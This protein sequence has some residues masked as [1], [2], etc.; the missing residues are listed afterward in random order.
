[1]VAEGQHRNNTRWRLPAEWERRAGSL[2]AWPYLPGPAQSAL[3]ALYVH[4]ISLLRTVEPVSLLVAPDDRRRVAG[5][6]GGED[7]SL[8]LE[9]LLSND[10][11]MRDAGPISVVNDAGQVLFL[12]GNFNGWGRRFAHELDTLLPLVLSR[13]WGYRRQRLGLCLEGGAIE[14]NGRGLGLTTTPVLTHPNRNNPGRQQI[15]SELERWLGVQDLVWLPHGLSMDHTDGHIDNLVRFVDPSHLVCCVADR[16][17]PD[18]AALS[19]NRAVVSAALGAAYT[20]I[21]LPTPQ[22]RSSSGQWL[23]ASHANFYLASGLALVPGF[24]DNSD[25]QARAKLQALLPRHEV[26]VVDCRAVLAHGGGLHCMIQP[27]HGH[28]AVEKQPA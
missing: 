26:I 15:E 24:G 4:L 8:R 16:D 6:L 1:M 21:D 3:E 25:D 18:A 20:L 12:D 13:R 17:H 11:W 10:I 22:F 19:E 7:E 28:L 5:L 23:A 9:P 2:L 14:V 27:L